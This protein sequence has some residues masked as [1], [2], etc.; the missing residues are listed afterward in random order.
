MVEKKRT[1]VDAMGLFASS[2]GGGKRDESALPP[3]ETVAALAARMKG[4]LESLGDRIRVRGEISNLVDKS[5]WY[6]SLKDDEAV[7]SCAMWASDVARVDFR[8][9]EGD[10]VIVT[11]SASFYA[12]QGRAQF[13]VRK[14][15]RVGLGSLQERYEALCRELRGLGYFDDARK[16]PLP[17]FPRRVAIVTSGTGA[18]IHD[19]LRTAALR[20]PAVG[21]VHVDV[22]V[23]G[24][25][26]ADEVARAIRALDRAA[27]SLA[28]DAIVVTRGGG[29][30]E[31]LWA[32]N[33]RVVADALFAP[34][35]IPVVAAIGHESDVTI[36]ELVADRRASTPTQAIT[37]L[38]PDREELSEQLDLL[39]DRLQS[40]LRRSIASRRELLV[41]VARSPVLRSPLA[42]VDLRRQRLLQRRDALVAATRMR[43]ADARRRLATC[44]S[45]LAAAQPSARLAHA[46]ATLADRA[47]RLDRALRRQLER[48]RDR[49]TS[50]GRQLDAV[51][52]SHVLARG[53]SY[54]LIRGGPRDGDLVRG[55]ADAPPGTSIETVIADGSVRSTVDRQTKGGP[56]VKKA[57]EGEGG[58]WE[59]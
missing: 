15:E 19:C 23:Q 42:A 21:I 3:P 24:A 59:E 17:T 33:E 34:R 36:A 9:K 45:G 27:D 28:I 51:A 43:L 6:F 48:A 14:I 12:K 50:L 8:P 26:A 53:F 25:G 54:T 47:A 7:V 37:F 32:F 55:V 10:E 44:A 49:A 5:H 2:S 46:R 41:R 11:G 30:I 22:R 38:V 35:R 18:A 40:S 39:R 1:F 52:P 4:A 57:E 31:D 13:Y 20:C 56:R 16:L 29:S 58:L